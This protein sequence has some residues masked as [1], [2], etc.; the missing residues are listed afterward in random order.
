MNLDGTHQKDRKTALTTK[1]TRLWHQ[2]DK[3]YISNDE[4]YYQQTKCGQHDCHNCIKST[5]ADKA[6]LPWE[7]FYILSCYITIVFLISS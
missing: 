6:P 2:V 3:N 7:Y 1:E 5:P 4:K